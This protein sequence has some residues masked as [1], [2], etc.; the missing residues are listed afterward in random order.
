MKTL[1]FDVETTGLDPIKNDIIQIAGIIDVNGNIYKEFEFK[2]QPFSYENISSE[3]LAVHGFTLDQLRTFEDP[4]S[5]KNKLCSL[6]EKYIE[7]FNTN[8]KFFPAGQNVRFDLDFLRQFFIKAGDNYFG[9]WFNYQTIDL[10]AIISVLRYAGILSLPNQKLIT[11]AS[12]FKIDLVEHDAL[13]DICA[14]RLAIKHIIENYI[15][16]P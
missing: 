12:H 4:I 2:V 7:K 11:I 16:R 5:V 15:K 8:D 14:T 13:S 3:A 9:S 6:F 10:Q 1:F